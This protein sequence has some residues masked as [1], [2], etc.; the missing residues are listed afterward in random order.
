[1]EPEFYKKRV[2]ENVVSE[3]LDYMAEDEDCGYKK[4]DVKKCEHILFKYLA[5]LGRLSAPSEQRIMEQVEKVVLAL[6]KL[7]EKTDY[8]LIET[9]AREEIWQIIQDSAVDCGL[10]PSVEDVTEEWREW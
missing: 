3:L 7:N 5:S 10:S 4:R 8:C 1:M 9:D 2:K 6:N